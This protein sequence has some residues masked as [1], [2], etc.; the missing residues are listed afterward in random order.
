[1]GMAVP[2][3]RKEFP[4]GAPALYTIAKNTV[5]VQY[6]SPSIEQCVDE[7]MTPTATVPLRSCVILCAIKYHVLCSWR[8]SEVTPKASG[9]WLRL[10]HL[11][12]SQVTPKAS[13]QW[14]R[15]WHLTFRRIPTPKK[16]IQSQR[17]QSLSSTSVN[18]VIDTKLQSSID[19]KFVEHKLT[20]HLEMFL[21]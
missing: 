18:R 21:H 10:R 7:T 9:Q 19:F 2:R 5:S 4:W 11:S 14:L 3:I 17:I 15:L 20:G 13:R 1:M 16:K 12:D 6:F 8:D